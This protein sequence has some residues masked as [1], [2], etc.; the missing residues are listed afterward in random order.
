M[1]AQRG[2]DS[3]LN[4]HLGQADVGVIRLRR[5]FQQ[6]LARQRAVYAAAGRPDPYGDPADDHNSH[7]GT[8]TPP[9]R[10]IRLLRPRTQTGV[11]P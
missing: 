3:R 4:E 11:T 7:N 8:T 1:E 2:I 6:E 5:F 10:P 9:L